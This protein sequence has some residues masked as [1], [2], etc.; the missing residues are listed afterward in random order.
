MSVAR[1]LQEFARVYGLPR[2]RTD[3]AVE[4]LRPHLSKYAEIVLAKSSFELITGGLGKRTG[5]ALARLALESGISP[6]AARSFDRCRRSFPGR[7]LG[8]KVCF[9]PRAAGPT[10]YVRVMA[11]LRD[12]LRFLDGI[13]ETAAL[14]K[15][16]SSN[17]ILYG[18][19]FFGAGDSLGVKTYS[20]A[21]LNRATVGFAS[22]RVV[23]DALLRRRKV[24]APAVAWEDLERRDARW[25]SILSV[26]RRLGYARA[27]HVSRM[28]GEGARSMK[29]YI[30]R[31]G[32]I[33]NDFSAR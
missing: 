27:G 3:R 28:V 1:E 12:G 25:R 5:T 6:A 22:Y 16:L 2:G 31:V 4:V 18:L 29:V 30:E 7:M 26:G 20:I 11:P 17:R 19:G 24:Y 23:N 9:G 8:L 14:R 33:E 10:L 13:C 32:A 21:Q 15:T